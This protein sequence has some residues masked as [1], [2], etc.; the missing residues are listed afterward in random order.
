MRRQRILVLMLLV[1]LAAAAATAQEDK[2]GSQ[3]RT[4]R[5]TVLDKQENPVVSAI[6]H[7]KNL[8]TL[9]VQTHISDD[10]GHFRFSGL[11]PNVDYEIHAQRGD[12][13]SAKRTLSSFDTGKE[14]VLNLKLDKKKPEK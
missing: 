3:L 14:I 2:R 1:V 10:A 13:V 5:G 6:V 9:M 11:D 12:M 8:R 4:V 7:L